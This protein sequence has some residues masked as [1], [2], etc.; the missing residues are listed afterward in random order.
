MWT[1][2]AFDSPEDALR[3]NHDAPSEEGAELPLGGVPPREALI[4]KCGED[5]VWRQRLRSVSHI[6]S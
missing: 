2:F 1:R 4:L 5:H 6:V 3:G